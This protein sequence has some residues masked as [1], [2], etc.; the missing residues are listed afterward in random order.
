MLYKGMIRAMKMIFIDKMKEDSIQK[1]L[2]ETGI[3]IEM[4]HANI[5]KLFEIYRDE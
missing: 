2:S 4:D 1:L 5:V 3:M